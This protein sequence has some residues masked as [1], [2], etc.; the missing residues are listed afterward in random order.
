MTFW[1][2]TVTGGVVTAA[3][4]NAPKNYFTAEGAA[5]LAELI[6]QWADP[7]VRCVVLTGTVPGCFITHYSVDEL[8]ELAADPAAL[9]A[10]GTG[11]NTGYYDMLGQLRALRKPVIAAINGDAMGGGFELCLWC[12]IRILAQGDYR[13]GLPETRLGIIPGGSGTQMLA[14]LLGAGK[15]I[16]MVMR[17]RLAAPDEALE[18]GLVHEVADDALARALEIAHDLA[19]QAPGAL[20]AAKAAIYGGS[21]MP[22]ADGLLVE[23][24]ESVG[25]IGSPEGLARMTEYLAQ[26]LDRRR[27]WL[28]SAV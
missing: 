7:S 22:L 3:Y 16:E 4:D 21:D 6:A 18:L 26:P 10:L 24:N 19:G 1:N 8:A 9:A 27:D 2:V 5:E 23:A 25:V 20:A 11:L 17:G 28:D 12:D 13:V 15:A 14:R